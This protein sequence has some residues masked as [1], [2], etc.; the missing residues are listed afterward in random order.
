[1]GWQIYVAMNDLPH[2]LVLFAEGLRVGLAVGVEAIF[3]ALLPGG[4]ELG[5]GDVPVWAAFFCDSAQVLAEIFKSGAA[6]E[7]IT[8]VD[9]VDHETGLENDDVGNHGI[10]DGVGVLG[11]VEIFLHDAACVGEEW[12]VSADS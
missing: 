4:P 7:P 10:V 2:S 11:D 1:M 12:P 6:E 5:C 9:F 8:V 3:V